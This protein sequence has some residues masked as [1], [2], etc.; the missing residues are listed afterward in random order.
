V[1]LIEVLGCILGDDV[2]VTVAPVWAIDPEVS[3]S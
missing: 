3:G 2:F 1:P